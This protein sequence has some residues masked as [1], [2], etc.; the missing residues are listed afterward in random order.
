MRDAGATISALRGSGGGAADTLWPQI[1]SDV[2]GLPQ[3][4]RA[5]SD[6]AGVGAALFAAMAVGAATPDTEWVT[7]GTPVV[8]SESLRS[9]YDELYG[10][11]RKLTLATLPQ[12]H[13]LA[14]WQ[15]D[16]EEPAA[17]ASPARPDQA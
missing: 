1:V 6:R 2:T 14:A 13:A 8:P 9:L 7:P 16:H 15:R 4:V 5:G 12:A 11:F 3:E 17:P 10:Q